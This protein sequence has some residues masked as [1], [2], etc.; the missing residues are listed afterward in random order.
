MVGEISTNGYLLTPEIFCE[1]IKLRI[2]DF[3]ICVDG[4]KDLHN[5]TRPHKDNPDSF[6]VIMNNINTIKRT[7]RSRNFNFTIRINVTPAV[8]PHLDSFLQ[9]LARELNGDPR[10]NVTI[11]CVRNWGGNS[12]DSS[13]LVSDESIVYRRWY[14]RIRELGLN[15]AST[16]HF[17]PFTYCTAYRR[18]GYIID[19]NASILKC[20]HTQAD[21]NHIGQIDKN[22]NAVLDDWKISNWFV[23][24]NI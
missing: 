10:F 21:I 23:S 22:G 7:V 15:G 13:Q 2:F 8:E 16:L 5:K 19:Y 18:N 14:S 12:I 11:Q 6:S 20:T 1:L 9:N 4:P 3:Q 24:I 17:T